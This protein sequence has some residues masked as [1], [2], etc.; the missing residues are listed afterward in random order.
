M[1]IRTIDSQQIVLIW[2]VKVAVSGAPWM[3]NIIDS[4]KAQTLSW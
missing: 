2:D 4:S 1:K 3:V